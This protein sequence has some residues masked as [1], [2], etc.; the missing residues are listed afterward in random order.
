MSLSRVPGGW[1]SVHSVIISRLTGGE[2]S[3]QLVVF[4]MF[5]PTTRAREIAGPYL[6]CLLLS[7]AVVFTAQVGAAT[8]DPS[9]A[10]QQLTEKRETLEA[11]LEQYRKTIDLLH[12]DE[13]PPEQSANPAVRSLAAETA[14][15]KQR[16]TEISEQEATLLQREP[17]AARNDREEPVATAA[18]AQP[19]PGAAMESRPLRSHAD[20]LSP[21]EAEAEAVSRL[22]GL[23]ENYYTELQESAAILPSAEEIE[24]REAAQRDAASL[25][26]IPYNVDKVRLSGNEG[27]MA[28]AQ[29]TRRLMDPLIPE[30]RRDIAP[31]CLIKTHLFDMLVSSENRS[32]TPVGKNHYIGRVRI[33]PGDTTLIIRSKQWDIRLPQ[34]A[35]AQDYLITLYRPEEGEAELHVF[36]VEDLLAVEDAHIP[37]WLPEE[38][39]IPSQSG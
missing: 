7:V 9:I 36:A 32:L 34:H 33:Q 27:S 26:V 30:S 24:A 14:A 10:L 37:A 13:I 1:T 22:H 20:G 8:A 28:L 29:I 16:L 38:L 12:T 25:K 31:I 17:V 4:Q 21:E 18:G 11:E 6:R 3:R 23:L 5:Y 19:G 39:K 2:L 15:L 35:N